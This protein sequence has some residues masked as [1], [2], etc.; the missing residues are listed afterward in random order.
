MADVLAEKGGRL[1]PFLFT[2]GLAEAAERQGA[3][4]ML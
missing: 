3:R 2:R 1:N 4:V